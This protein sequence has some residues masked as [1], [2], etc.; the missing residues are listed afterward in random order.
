MGSL[1]EDSAALNAAI[2]EF[3]HQRFDPNFPLEII[4]LAD[5]APTTLLYPLGFSEMFYKSYY[6][7]WGKETL[8]LGEVS[9]FTIRP[10]RDSKVQVFPKADIEVLRW[11]EGSGGWF[12]IWLRLPDRRL[13]LNLWESH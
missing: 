4:V 13:R 9:S 1:F 3:F 7:G 5:S 10:R 11:K 8:L 12:A 2:K 6:V